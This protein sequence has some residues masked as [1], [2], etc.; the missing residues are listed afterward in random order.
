MA[1]YRDIYGRGSV[2]IHIFFFRLV[3]LPNHFKKSPR[4]L[5]SKEAANIWLSIACNFVKMCLLV[6]EYTYVF[7]SGVFRF[8]DAWWVVQTVQN[9]ITDYQHKNFHVKNETVLIKSEN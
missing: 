3:L 2:K 8:M 7:V 5:Y 1:Q 6:C 9:H 4:N